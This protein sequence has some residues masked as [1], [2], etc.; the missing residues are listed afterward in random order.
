MIQSF[1]HVIQNFAIYSGLQTI[2]VKYD[3]NHSMWGL[4]F[5][6]ISWIP[7]EIQVYQL[8]LY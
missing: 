7:S 3:G 8:N 1:V 4:V 6:K 2:S 5:K